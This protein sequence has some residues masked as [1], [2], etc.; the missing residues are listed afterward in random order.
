[1][2]DPARISRDPVGRAVRGRL[3][4]GFASGRPVRQPDGQR[5]PLA[6]RASPIG[7]DDGFRH[8]AGAPI[9]VLARFIGGRTA[10]GRSRGGRR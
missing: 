8:L 1:M 9:A 5:I 3:H 7:H 10:V 4:D 2:V 6:E